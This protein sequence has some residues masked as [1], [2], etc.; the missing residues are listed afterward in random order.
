[1]RSMIDALIKAAGQLFE[2][3]SWVV[4]GKSILI[5]AMLLGGLIWLGMA[6]VAGVLE[7]DWGWFDWLVDFVAEF[8]VYLAALVLFPA[9]VSMGAALF[10]DD[11]AAAVER[12]HYPQDPPG[13]PLGFKRAFLVGAR[14]GLVVLAVNILVLPFYVAFLFFPPASL[15]LYYLVNGFLL[16]RE[17]LELVGL[18][19]MGE[20]ELWS[21]RR[22]NSLTLFGAGC[23]IAFLFSVPGVN[24]A[25]PIL[26]A[27]FMMH[28]FK[29]LSARAPKDVS[30]DA[31]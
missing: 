6:A 19:H 22:A 10:L 15:A 5:S 11:I 20:R 25:A 7:T 18:R 21:L 14:L 28:I 12:R 3:T 1:M 26:G 17:Y 4:L 31:A 29:K 23:L 9:T 2:R 8:V 24:L 27:A 16:S 13:A 30:G